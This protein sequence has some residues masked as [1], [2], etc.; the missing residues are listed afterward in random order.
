MNQNPEGTSYCLSSWWTRYWERRDPAQG[1]ARYYGLSLRQDLWG[2]WELI[3]S[4]GRIGHKPTREVREWIRG[5]AEAAVIA[6]QVH[7]R[8]VQHRYALKIES[9]NTLAGMKERI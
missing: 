1:V 2:E 4:W 7:R 3:R 6:D 5:P 8:R 9:A